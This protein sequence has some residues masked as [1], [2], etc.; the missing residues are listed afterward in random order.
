M[1]SPFPGMDPWLEDFWRDVH[2]RLVIY[3]ADQLQ[4]RLPADLRA[5]VEERVV[6]EPLD[7]EPC[8][9]YPD[10]RIAERGHG[11][12]L[13]VATETDVAVAEPLVLRVASE[14]RTE[15]YIQIIDVG[16]GKRVVTVLEILS[17]ANKLPGD[18]RNQYRQ[19]PQEL[20]AGEV[21]LVEIDLLRSGTWT[22]NVAEAII[23]PA[24]RT[25][26]RVVV[27]RGWR[28]DAIEIYRV[29]LRE[30]LPA[31]WVPL[32]EKD[33]DVPLDLQALIDQCYRNGGYDDDLD[34][35]RGPNHP[36]DPDDAQ[37]ADELLRAQGRR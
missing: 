31:I 27:R 11:R 10:V 23:P 1:A 13:A 4:G 28:H 6:V 34:Y 8:S 7:D 26:Y 33:E 17:L 19:K 25:T 5:R 18:G 32:R 30:R 22:V 16:T 35:R 9:A 37:W 29:P 21:S 15:T 20:R 2:A 3:A 14:P 36:L 24:F 12:A